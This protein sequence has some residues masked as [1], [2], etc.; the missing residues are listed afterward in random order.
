M[1]TTSHIL[2]GLP[3][4]SP[5]Y[6]QQI[7]NVGGNAFD[8]NTMAKRY[9]KYLQFSSSDNKYLW[10]AAGDSF[11]I[12]IPCHS[13]TVYKISHS[14]T[15]ATI[16][17]CAYIRDTVIPEEAGVNITAY[18]TFLGTT[19][20]EHTITTGEGATYLIFQANANLMLDI[21]KTLQVEQLYIQ[22][23]KSSNFEDFFKY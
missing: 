9:Y 18:E 6:T 14:Y 16:F 1:G 12:A 17:R 7:K 11:S 15:G 22:I 13:N 23:K 10:S 2:G 19:E 4:P 8:I 21:I 20:T 3:S 5:N